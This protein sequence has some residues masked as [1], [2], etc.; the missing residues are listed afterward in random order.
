MQNFQALEFPKFQAK[1]HFHPV[2]SAAGGFAP[3]LQ[4]PAARGFAPRPPQNSPPL[5]IS[6]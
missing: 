6:G 1:F 3:D 4:P 5:R 2:Y